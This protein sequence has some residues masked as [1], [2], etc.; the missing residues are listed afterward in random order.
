MNT[1]TPGHAD[2]TAAITVSETPGILWIELT[3]KCPFKCVFCSRELLRGNGEHMDIAVYRKLISELT[4]PQVIRLNYSGESAHYPHLIEAITLAKQKDAR[5]ELVSALSSIRPKLIEPLIRSGLDLLCVSIHTLDTRQ[6]QDIYGFGSTETLLQRLE[7]LRRTQAGTGISTPRLEFALVAMERNL[8]QISA[9]MSLAERFD[10]SRLDIHPVIRR[11]PIAETFSQELDGS[12]RLRQ[13][14]IDRLSEHVEVSR[15]A[16][17]TVHTSFSTPEIDAPP[18]ILGELPQAY[19]ARLPARAKILTCEQNPWNTMHVLANGDVVSCEVRDRQPIGNLGQASLESIWHGANYQDFRRQFVLAQDAKCAACAYKTAYLPTLKPNPWKLFRKSADQTINIVKRF[20]KT[21]IAHSAT[22]GLIACLAIAQGMGRVF[23]Q[24]R[25][26][27][28]C[29]QPNSGPSADGSGIS[30]IIPERDS[31]DLLRQCL[32]A[33]YQAIAGCDC[34]CEVI[35]VVNG[36]SR[37]RYASLGSEFP[38]VRWNFERPWLGFARAIGQGLN[39]TRFSWVFLLNNDMLLEP[40]ALHEVY[41]YR[42]EHIFAIACQIFMADKTKRREETGF[43]GLNPAGG[44]QGLYD[45]SPY[46]ETLPS[47]HLYAGGGASLFQKAL[48]S[49][50]IEPRGAYEPFYWEDVDWGIRAQQ[51]AYQV[52]FVPQAKAHHRHRATVSRFFSEGE[53][54]QWFESNAL[55]SGLSHGWFQ[56]PFLLL[57]LKL[58]QYRSSVFRPSRLSAMMKKR[59]DSGRA[60]VQ[61]RL[62]NDD[63]VCFFP[64]APVPGDQRPWLLLV[65]PYLLYPLSHGG[66]V[67]ID[68]ISRALA[69]RYRLVLVCDEGWGFDPAHAKQLNQFEAVHLLLRPRADMAGDRLARMKGHAR[70]LLCQEVARALSLYRPSIVQIEYEELCDLVKLKRSGSGCWFIT[71]HDVNRGDKHTDAYLDRRLR[72]FDGV[73]CCSVEDQHLLPLKSHLVENGASLSRF[74]SSTPSRGEELLFIG[75]FRYAPN[76]PAIESFI[77]DVFPGLTARFPGLQLKV[78]CGDEGMRFAHEVPFNHPKIELIAHSD[79]INQHLQAATLTINPLRGIAGSCLKT[80]ESLAAHRICVSSPDA[81]RGL[82]H[83]EFPGLLLADS[84][85][86]FEQI[87]TSLL[88]DENLRHR[89]EKPPHDRIHHFNWNVRA[90]SQMVTYEA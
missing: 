19:P 27:S 17:P 32:G 87:I 42:S 22:V 10:V 24:V 2:Q 74:S 63:V 41:R 84:P 47:T 54:D 16:F 15:L 50:L 58:A 44:L 4:A 69:L 62:S 5:V 78:L 79:A 3:S 67:R 31:P 68:A 60:L 64:R 43:T 33:L 6:Y 23:R 21:S 46:L 9:V 1:S 8:D 70:P 77:Y 36:T 25:P 59:F 37:D 48:L 86:Q 53:I 52:A 38:F 39:I 88:E 90:A 75:P 13:D 71:L 49:K 11:D 51:L 56:P 28:R 34:E 14:F 65:T 81:A 61:P 30:V 80:I 7:L 29:F 82:T 18:A 85:R 12:N 66:A 73:F 72:R 26:Q 83:F 45:G 20:A 35:V 76:R 55:L 40:E 89:L 57:S